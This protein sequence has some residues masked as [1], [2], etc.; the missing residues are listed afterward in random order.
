MDSKRRYAISH[1]VKFFFENLVTTGHT[2]EP[3]RTGFQPFFEFFN[4]NP[5][6]T[7]SWL[8]KSE[9]HGFVAAV[10]AVE[11]LGLLRKSREKGAMRQQ[12]NIS[13]A[14]EKKTMRKN[15]AH[16]GHRT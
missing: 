14:S 10:V 7:A 16:G 5:S 11:S 4:S 3:P 9:L 15:L 1:V 8:Q 12:S 6:P 13:D 2:K